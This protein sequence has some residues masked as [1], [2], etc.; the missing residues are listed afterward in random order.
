MEAAGVSSR[1]NFFTS[2]A[3]SHH[4]SVGR[5]VRSKKT[6]TVGLTG[7]RVCGV[8][9]T[10]LSDGADGGSR[11]WRTESD[12]LGLLPKNSI[13]GCSYC[14]DRGSGNEAQYR[15][16]RHPYLQYCLPRR[17]EWIVL[18]LGDGPCPSHWAHCPNSDLYWPFREHCPGLAPGD[19]PC[20]CLRAHCPKSCMSNSVPLRAHCPGNF[21]IVSA[22]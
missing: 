21:A 11:S 18:A 15:Y 16:P 14:P 8:C 20:P 7:R 9:S 10:E 3:R 5:S 13:L 17:I 12:S 22:K 1:G 2:S 6:A 4:V 19:G